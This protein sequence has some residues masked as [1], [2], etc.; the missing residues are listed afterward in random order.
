MNIKQ[1]V[2][3]NKDLTTEI[4]SYV[5]DVELCHHFKNNLHKNYEKFIKF[6]NGTPKTT[7]I[8]GQVQSGKTARIIQY[9]K[10]SFIKIKILLVQNS[11]SMVKQY[12]TKFINNN[13]KYFVVCKQNINTIVNFIN[14]NIYKNIILIVMNNSFRLS[15]LNSIIKHTKIYNYT[16][17]MDESDLY[18]RQIKPSKLYNNAYECVHITATPFLKSYENYFDKFINIVPPDNY[19]GINKL[20]IIN[21]FDVMNMTN[22]HINMDNIYKIITNDFIQ[23]DEESIMLINIYSTINSMKILAKYLKNKT[24]LMNVP[25]VVLSSDTKLYFNNKIKFMRKL[26]VTE[27]IDELIEHKHIILIANRLSSRGINYTDSNYKRCLT[28]QILHNKNNKTSF[29]QKCR[30][31]GIKPT[32]NTSTTMDMNKYKMYVFNYSDTLH[33]KILDKVNSICDKKYLK[34]TEEDKK[35]LIEKKKKEE[36]EKRRRKIRAKKEQEEQEERDREAEEIQQEL[37]RLE[38]ENLGD[39]DNINSNDSNNINNNNNDKKNVI[40]RK[41]IIRIIE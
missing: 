39:N 23:N 3:N 27:T 15:A 36:K 16:L 10:D 21:N 2:F 34:L 32:T 12:E 20:N 14:N 37:E 29:L 9:I 26:T 33:N 5:G 28:H 13:L 31:M 19:L 25:I 4:F 1:F 8:Y 6:T 7:L 24:N 35:I 30:I 18:F 11:L 38:L 17:M 22:D 41:K 40:V